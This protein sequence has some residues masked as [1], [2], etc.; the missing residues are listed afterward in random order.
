MLIAVRLKTAPPTWPRPDADASEKSMKLSFRMV[1]LILK[2]NKGVTGEGVEVTSVGKVV[3]PGCLQPTV[4]EAATTLG[5][6][7]PSEAL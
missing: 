1:E 3:V 4:N 2:S 6:W 7:Q 5:D